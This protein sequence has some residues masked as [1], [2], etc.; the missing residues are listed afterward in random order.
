MALPRFAVITN[1]PDNLAERAAA[2]LEEEMGSVADRGSA[3]RRRTPARSERKATRVP[4][5]RREIVAWAQTRRVRRRARKKP[6]A[7]IWAVSSSSRSLPLDEGGAEGKSAALADEAGGDG[8]GGV[9]QEGGK[10]DPT[11]LSF[12]LAANLPLGDEGRHELLAMDSV[13]MRLRWVSGCHSGRT[14]YKHRYHGARRCQLLRSLLSRAVRI[15]SHGGVSG[16]SEE[17]PCGMM[18]PSFERKYGGSWGP[19]WVQ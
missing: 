11:I 17:L 10:T 5:C 3:S 2:L 16:V 15:P 1:S 19:W 12:R 4:T 14:A 13:V 9:I 7:G 6:V 18:R 8:G